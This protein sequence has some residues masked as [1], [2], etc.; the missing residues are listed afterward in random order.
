MGRA[1]YVYAIVR[2]DVRLPPVAGHRIERVELGGVAAAAERRTRARPLS[3]K[4]LRDQYRVIARLHARVDAI[5]PVRFGALVEAEELERIVALRRR[6]LVAALRNVRNRSQ[7]TVRLLGSPIEAVPEPDAI[8]GTAYLLAR[9]ESSRPVLSPAAEAIRRSVAR[10]VAAESIDR[11]RGSIALTLHHLVAKDRLARY[12][13]H[14][15]SAAADFGSPASVVI[16][17]PMAPFAF[18]PD[19][20]NDA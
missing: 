7:M 17:G 4:T 16:S 11:G 19:L 6:T 9:V 5:L 14:V 10:L 12:R 2:S 15:E 13:A 1:L 18:V 3:E 8:T 20:W